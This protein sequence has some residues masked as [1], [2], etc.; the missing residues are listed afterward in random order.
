VTKET[1][2]WLTDPA[3]INDVRSMVIANDFL[4]ILNFNFD[5]YFISKVSIHTAT[6][7]PSWLTDPAYLPVNQG[8][9]N[10][11]V[12]IAVAGNN[13]YILNIN[14]F[15]YFI[16][17]V[18]LETTTGNPSWCQL[19]FGSEYHYAPCS[20]SIG[21][22]YLYTTFSKSLCQINLETAMPTIIDVEELDGN[23][24]L[25]NQGKNIY[26]IT[27]MRLPI[28]QLNLDTWTVKPFLSLQSY[29]SPV[30]AQMYWGGKFGFCRMST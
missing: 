30:Y 19:P 7:N 12:S 28:Y 16:S 14:T 11:P 9:R 6:G 25:V 4:Y 29:I 15:P 27:L 24:I 8:N 21:G 26:Y 2:P 17:Q 22:N 13:L 1:I 20:L 5:Y 10:G 3:Y 23:T 18:N